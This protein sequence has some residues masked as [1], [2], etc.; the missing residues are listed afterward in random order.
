MNDPEQDL[1]R[2]NS[3]ARRIR[4]QYVYIGAL[5][6]LVAGVVMA[7]AFA[8]MDATL[9][10]GLFL[11]GIVMGSLAGYYLGSIRACELRV[12]AR[13]AAATHAVPAVAESLAEAEPSGPQR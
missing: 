8:G 3:F 13:M 11:L 5:L 6:G 1:Q 9:A 7:A 12:L 10:G 4:K 2:L